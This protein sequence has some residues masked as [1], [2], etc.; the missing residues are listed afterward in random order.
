MFFEL[1]HAKPCRIILKFHPKLCFG[2]EAREIEPKVRNRTCPGG[3]RAGGPAV[4]GRTGGQRAGE[5][6]EK[7]PCGTLGAL[8]SPV[9]PLKGPAWTHILSSLWEPPF[10]PDTLGP[11][12]ALKQIFKEILKYLSKSLNI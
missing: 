3:R 6:L 2:P 7:E 12:G 4:S 8:W 10:V 1:L 5:P 11:C 9:E